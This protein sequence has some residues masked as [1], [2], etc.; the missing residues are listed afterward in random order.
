V[1]TFAQNYATECR[2]H[3]KLS[4]A[5]CGTM[6]F[7]NFWFELGRKSGNYVECTMFYGADFAP[8]WQNHAVC[9]VHTTASGEKSGCFPQ[10]DCET[11]S[12]TFI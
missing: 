12:R 10:P 4:K 1:T 6:H 8:Y 11:G 2:K 3:P 9:N 7:T 5:E